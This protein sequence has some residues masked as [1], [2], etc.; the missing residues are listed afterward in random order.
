MRTMSNQCP[1]QGA[2]DSAFEPQREAPL[3]HLRRK[4]MTIVHL[5]VIWYQTRGT[6][7]VGTS[8]GPTGDTSLLQVWPGGKANS[9][10]SRTTIFF[11]LGKRYDFFFGRWVKVG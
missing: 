1:A 9:I 3:V 10:L 6:T 7:G 8:T 5:I 4:Q 2:S 11:F